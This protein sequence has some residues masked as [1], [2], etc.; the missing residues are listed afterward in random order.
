MGAVVVGVPTTCQTPLSGQR[1]P[2][3]AVVP[4]G[5][6]VSIISYPFCRFLLTG[7]FVALVICHNVGRQV[8]I[9]H[10]LHPTRFLVNFFQNAESWS[11]NEWWL[12]TWGSECPRTSMRSLLPPIGRS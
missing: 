11:I 2:V 7:L 8:F 1:C 5:A 6:F 9:Y 10:L 3:C 4:M 12:V